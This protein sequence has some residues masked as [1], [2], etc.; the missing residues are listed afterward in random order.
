MQ[1]GETAC[2]LAR[3]V[4]LS[5]QLSI[6]VCQCLKERSVLPASAQLTLPK[7]LVEFQRPSDSGKHWA[8]L[9]F[10]H[11]NYE[12]YGIV[13]TP[14]SSLWDAARCFSTTY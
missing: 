7:D 8:E 13:S 10:V 14:L 2:F 12:I 5:F 6:S 1:L 4:C 11:I 3:H 9:F